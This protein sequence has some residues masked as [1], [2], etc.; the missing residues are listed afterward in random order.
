MEQSAEDLQGLE[1]KLAALDSERAKLI[2]QINTLRNASSSKAEALPLLLGRRSFHQ[3]PVTPDEK[4]KLF[5]SFFRCRENIYP[6][7][8]EN[9]KTGKSGYAPACG[10]EWVKPICQKPQIKC[11]DCKFQKFLPLDESAARAHLQEGKTIGT[12]AFNES[13]ACIFL[14]CDFDEADWCEDAL[15]YQKT[16]RELG[17]EVAIEQSRSGNGAHAWIFFEEP[18]PARIARSLGTLILAKCSERSTR[19]SLDSYD[20]L[21]PSQDYLPRG[22]FG[23]LIAL[24]LQRVPRERGYSC[25][26]DHDF[27]P[28]TNQW[29]Y[30]S[31]IRKISLQEIKSV[32]DKWVP[33]TIQTKAHDGFD[34]LAWNTDLSILNKSTS[35]RIEYS[36]DGK[37]IEIELGS[38]ISIPLESLS[39]K[40]VAKLRK[41]ASFPNPEFYK[42]QRMRMQ[43]YPHR[44]FIFSGELRP[45]Q[46][47]LPRGVLDEVV[48]ILSIAGADVIICDARIAKKKIKTE[49]RGELTEVQAQ[50]VKACKSSDVG[51]LVAPPGAGKTVIGCAMIA[52]RKVSTL[53]LVH[54]QELLNQWKKRIHEFLNVPV[55]EIGCPVRARSTQFGHEIKIS[56]VSI[57]G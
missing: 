56:S 31:Q 44:R 57:T 34:D 8:W 32:L 42:L 23:N 26:L 10:N 50:A 24:P 7:R 45:D 49:F 48:K 11:S 25:F 51:I 53:V 30:L 38:M 14:A 41:S 12:Y 33:K 27:Q 47:I 46:I 21:F 19:L 18:I 40:I 55:K 1:E 28:Y 16:A 2:L 3:P 52:Q 37:T 20:R 9:P 22:G 36:L 6:K 43:T 4:I 13:D 15:A 54:R 5:L 35:D 39:G 29:E 17:I